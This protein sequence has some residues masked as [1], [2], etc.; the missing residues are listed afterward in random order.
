LFRQLNLFCVEC[1][2]T[3]ILDLENGEVIC[4]KCGLVHDAMQNFTET[5]QIYAR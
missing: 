4:S 1:G 5:K 3:L 2:G